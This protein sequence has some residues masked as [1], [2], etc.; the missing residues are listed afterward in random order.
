MTFAMNF[1][2]FIS[3]RGALECMRRH[4]KLMWSSLAA[5]LGDLCTWKIYKYPDLARVKSLSIAQPLIFEISGCAHLGWLARMLACTVA[6]TGDGG[7]SSSKKLST[8]FRQIDIVAPWC[9]F[10]LSLL[11]SVDFNFMKGSFS[12]TIFFFLSSFSISRDI[13]TFQSL[14]SDFSLNFLVPPL[15]RSVWCLWLIATSEKSRLTSAQQQ[16]ELDANSSAR[17]SAI[18]PLPADCQEWKSHRG[19]GAHST[20][21]EGDDLAKKKEFQVSNTNRVLLTYREWQ[22]NNCY[23]KHYL[24]QCNRQCTAFGM[25]QNEQKIWVLYRAREKRVWRVRFAAQKSSNCVRACKE[26]DSC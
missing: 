9:N 15:L 3:D 24:L 25:E 8:N 2:N 23:N 1:H 22:L 14:K 13:N 11:P 10:K 16:Q 21:R 26:A 20:Q 4:R 12:F 7:G 18:I 17:Y 5:S 6:L 19:G